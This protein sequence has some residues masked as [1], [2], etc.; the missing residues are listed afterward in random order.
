MCYFNVYERIVELCPI[1]PHFFCICIIKKIAVVVV[2]LKKIK[3]LTLFL[4]LLSR[5]YYQLHCSLQNLIYIYIYIFKK[6]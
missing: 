5:M 4:I 2:F 1:F 3:R 6:L